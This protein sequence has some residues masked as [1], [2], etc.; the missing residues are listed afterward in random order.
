MGDSRCGYI[1][2]HFS[3]TSSINMKAENKANA[4]DDLRDPIHPVHEYR[5]GAVD[6]QQGREAHYSED[7]GSQQLDKGHAEPDLFDAVCFEV[8]CVLRLCQVGHQDLQLVSYSFFGLCR[9]RLG[10]PRT[11]GGG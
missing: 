10:D 6:R 7:A 9:V 4:A 2:Y 1:K 3:R 5:E 8:V 11:A